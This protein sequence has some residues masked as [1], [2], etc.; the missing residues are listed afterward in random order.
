[1]R[2]IICA[3]MLGVFLIGCTGPATPTPYVYRTP[4][5]SVTGIVQTDTFSFTVPDGWGA[6]TTPPVATE[7]PYGYKQ[8]NLTTLYEVA[9]TKYIPR[10]F[11]TMRVIPEGSTLQT[12]ADL[13]YAN[14]VPEINSLTQTTGEAAGLP[15]IILRYN[16]PWG[17]PWYT[18]EDTWVEH[19]GTAY[20]FSCWAAL[21]ATDE[22]L[23]P[24]RSLV[25]SFTFTP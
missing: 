15:A 6:F 2:A 21:N 22:Q 24:C 25:N 23:A 1:M 5:G 20:V 10:F 9:G 14:I 13:T 12:E 4:T 8:L 17:E 3:I 11:I 7:V 19:A 16:Q 18:F